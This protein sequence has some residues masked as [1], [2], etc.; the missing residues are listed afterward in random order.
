MALDSDAVIVPGE[1]HFYIADYGSAE[2]TGTDAPTT[3]WEEAG[4]TPYDTGFTLNREGGESTVLR[5]WQ[6]ESLRTRL[7]PT[8]Y[9]LQFVPLQW[10]EAA[11][12]LYFGGGSINTV[13][14][15]FEVPKTPVPQEKALYVR[16]VDGTD[17]W[18]KYI[19]KVEIIGSDSIEANPEELMG[20]PVTATILDDDA[21]DFLFAIDAPT[22]D[23][24]TSV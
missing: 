18:T 23:A 5:S 19:S 7:D 22:F 6:S 17:V 2:P 3:P 16:V 10:D 8:T 21:V 4:H 9:T 20:M 12:Q 14:G 15:K 11:M 24:P 1:G 13:T